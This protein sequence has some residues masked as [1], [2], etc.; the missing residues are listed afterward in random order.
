MGGNSN[1]S[2]DKISAKLQTT[3]VEDTSAAVD[4]LQTIDQRR[5]EIKQQLQ[6]NV[7]EKNELALIDQE[8]L[9]TEIKLLIQS[10]LSVLER[11]DQDIKVGTEARKYEVFAA[12]TNAVTAQLKELRELNKMIAD[13]EIF[14]N[15][16]AGKPQTNVN[17]EMNGKDLLDW[18]DK[19]RSEREIDRIVPEFNI[20]AD[21]PPEGE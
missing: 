7:T 1:P 10:T 14:K 11:L 18:L 8:Y 19:V 21:N 15:P 5:E 13:M 4:Q 20:M 9:L 3:F 16:S 12:L 6:K 17:V 2:F